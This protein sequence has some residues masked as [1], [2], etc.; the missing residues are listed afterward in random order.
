ML[1]SLH[2]WTLSLIC[3]SPR[4]PALWWRRALVLCRTWRLVSLPGGGGVRKWTWLI[5]EGR[6]STVASTSSLPPPSLLPPHSTPA[7]NRPG[8]LL[9]NTWS[10]SQSLVVSG[11][12][13]TCHSSEKNMI[14]MVI[15]RS[16][17]S[18][19]L[20]RVKGGSNKAVFTLQF[21]SA[22]VNNNLIS[23]QHLQQGVYRGRDLHPGV[24]TVQ[25]STSSCTLSTAGSNNHQTLT[26]I[27]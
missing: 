22:L 20:V 23:Q 18:G 24:N 27:K 5:P 1:L 10:A 3:A 15:A 6:T 4:D 16:L 8:Q 14:S 17:I 9:H 25:V 26:T 2:S 7:T 11:F 19:W 21:P 12:T 13:T